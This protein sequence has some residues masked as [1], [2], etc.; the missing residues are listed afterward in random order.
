MEQDQ[1]EFQ[2]L[3]LLNLDPFRGLIRT[4]LRKEVQDRCLAQSEPYP[5]LSPHGQPRPICNGPISIASKD[6][7]PPTQ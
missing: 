1:E 3:S 4:Q 5:H 6:S 7:C 2:F